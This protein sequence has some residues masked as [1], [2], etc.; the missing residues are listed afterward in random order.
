MKN[1]LLFFLTMTTIQV[2]G[3]EIDI[4]RIVNP[5]GVNVNFP[6]EEGNYWQ[7][8]EHELL[9]VELA[10][11]RDINNSLLACDS[12]AEDLS[13]KVALVD[14][15][16]C[17]IKDKYA[18]ATAKN[19][20]GF[21]LCQT[22]DDPPHELGTFGPPYIPMAMISK[23]TCDS[24]RFYLDQGQVFIDWTNKAIPDCDVVPQVKAASCAEAIDLGVLSSCESLR[25]GN[26]SATACNDDS[27][28]E[29]CYSIQYGAIWNKFELEMGINAISVDLRGY[30][31]QPFFELFK[32]TDCSDLEVLDICLDGEGVQVIS[33]LEEG[34]SYFFTSGET[35]NADSTG[36]IINITDQ[37]C[38]NTFT[39]RAFYDENDNGIFDPDEV[40]LSH[41]AFN[42]SPGNRVFYS[43]TSGYFNINFPNGKDT[44]RLAKSESCWNFRDISDQYYSSS[45][46]SDQSRDIA[47]V[48]TEINTE[49]LRV[50]IN[51][52]PLRCNMTTNFWV[53]IENIGCDQFSGQ[54]NLS[55]PEEISF[56][57]EIGSDFGFS[58]GE[59]SAVL[60][61]LNASEILTLRFQGQV[62]DESF[63]GDTVRIEGVVGVYTASYKEVITCAI[64]PNDKQVLPSRNYPNNYT[65]NSELINYKVRF[66]NTGSDTAFTV[67][68][69]DTLSSYLDWSSILFLSSSHTGTFTVEDGILTMLYKDIAL[70]DST[71]NEPESH[72]FFTFEIAVNEGVEDFTI[73]ENTASIYFDLN[74]PIHTNTTQSAIVTHLDEDTDGYFFWEECDD[75]NYDVNPGSEE[76]PN[77]DV[78]EDCDGVLGMFNEEDCNVVLDD[79]SSYDEGSFIGQD[80]VNWIL[81]D[82]DSKNG[83]IFNWGDFQVLDIASDYNQSSEDYDAQIVQELNLREVDQASISFNYYNECGIIALEFYKDSTFE[84]F[85]EVVITSFDSGIENNAYYI[86]QDTFGNCHSLVNSF[87]NYEIGLIFNQDE[88]HFYC[89]SGDTIKLPFYI[90]ANDFYGIGWGSN[91]CAYISDLC[92]SVANAVNTDVDGD[93]F[94]TSVDCDDNDVTIN[95]EAEEI[96]NNGIDENCDGEDLV[97]SLDDIVQNDIKVFPNPVKEQFA[98]DLGNRE[99]KLKIFNAQGQ[100]LHNIDNFRS[101]HLIDFRQQMKGVYF[102]LVTDSSGE[103]EVVKLINI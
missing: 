62:E 31:G 83:T 59:L 42:A 71:T 9:N 51:S 49:N 69:I 44:I 93:G 103:S 15:G 2:S 98:V 35:I 45:A 58:E 34:A 64:D 43:D 22:N 36:S 91:Q 39:G 10:Q 32:G 17:F 90:D 72:G 102:L 48:K 33:G 87:A 38:T 30:K 56:V 74:Q 24:L 97:S 37:T 47:L 67:E 27:P 70:V 12:I 60:S 1:I 99:G 81:R 66:Q 63:E 77:N 85:A 5:S 61:N 28:A 8:P 96:P 95:P 68:I 54:V 88:L 21:I 55:I 46:G 73:V 20:M 53:T 94:D 29:S 65:L 52:S 16:E 14:R 41:I 92:I 19:A 57:D 40:P 18:R 89:P 78:D 25:G 3:Q 76:I 80:S 75:T 4:L 100:E 86:Q 101:K 50:T 7:V 26:Y 84:K 82:E 79:F 13:N 23:E 6:F 11:V